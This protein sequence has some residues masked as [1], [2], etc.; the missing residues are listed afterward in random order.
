MGDDGVEFVRGIEEQDQTG[1]GGLTMSSRGR[2][3]A[4]VSRGGGGKGAGCTG[5][6][7]RD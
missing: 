6:G 5:V 2:L 1:G 7:T 3:A 4:E